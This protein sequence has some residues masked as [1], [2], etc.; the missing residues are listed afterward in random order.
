MSS[1]FIKTLYRKYITSKG[2]TTDTIIF[3]ATPKSFNIIVAI[4][5][6]TKTLSTF[7]YYTCFLYFSSFILIYLIF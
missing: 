4:M 1:F 7:F 6:N 2:I 5:A 3:I